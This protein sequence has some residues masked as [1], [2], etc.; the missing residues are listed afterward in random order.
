MSVKRNLQTLAVVAAVT[1]LGCGSGGVK[2]DGRDLGEKNLGLYLRT[3][4]DD[5]AGHRTHQAPHGGVLVPLGDHFANLEVVLD[6]ESGQLTLFVLSCCADKAVRIAQKEI[7]LEL[8]IGEDTRAKTFTVELAAKASVLTGEKVGDTS[9]FTGAAEQLKGV[10]GFSGKVVAA[11]VLG[12]TFKDVPF[13]F[14]KGASGG[15]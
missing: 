11:E 3:G 1:L 8:S 6:P 2:D 13:E 10:G 12:R 5:A 7:K 4:H 14:T 15:Q 9:E